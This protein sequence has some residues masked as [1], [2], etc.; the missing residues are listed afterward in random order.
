[1]TKIT[2]IIH[3]SDLHVRTFQ[4][5]KEYKEILTEFLKQVKDIVDENGKDNTIIVL[6]GDIFHNKILVSNEQNMIVAWLFTEMAK[7]CKTYILAGN[8]DALINNSD[9]IDSIT[10]IIK[11]LNNENLVYLDME[12]GYKSGFYECEG[13]NIIFPVFS[14]FDD[15]S[16]LDI[17]LKRIDNPDKIFLSL[18][19]GMTVGLRNEHNMVFEHGKSLEMFDGSS[20][21]LCGDVHLRQE[22]EYNGIKIVQPSSLIQQGFGESA[23]SGHGYCL[24]NLSDEKNI[25]YEAIDIDNTN[26]GFYKFKINSVE[27]I[28]NGTESFVNF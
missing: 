10:P 9:R 14:V 8:H 4:R 20:A 27:D 13:T 28:D 23:K 15:H 25:T 6:A 12:L 24:W 2:R 11:M 1:M 21:V 5:H 7:L 3:Y 16:P 18:F 19:H 22:Q 26:Y 17:K